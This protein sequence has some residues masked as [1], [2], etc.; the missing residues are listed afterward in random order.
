MT[1]V[2]RLLLTVLIAIPLFAIPL[3]SPLCVAV[4]ISAE[5]PPAAKAAVF[6]G[7]IRH[8]MAADRFLR[9]LERDGRLTREQDAA[10]QQIRD[11]PEAFDD[12]VA[13]MGGIK[14][15]KAVMG[16]T[17]APFL[18]WLTNVGKWMWE[19]REAI[20]KFI[21]EIVKLFAVNSG[22][23]PPYPMLA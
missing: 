5:P 23:A 3:F 11:N 1:R 17:G 21:M 19:N 22:Q 2:Q 20:M 9:K 12:F 16:D 13:G 8:R 18:D 4:L 6:N 7:Q 10:V 15:A 14:G